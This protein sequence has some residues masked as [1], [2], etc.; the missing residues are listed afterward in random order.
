MLDQARQEPSVTIVTTRVPERAAKLG[1]R[2]TAQA[3]ADVM[4]LAGNKYSY[5]VQ[6]I[7]PGFRV[8]VF[9]EIIHVPR[10]SRAATCASSPHDY[11]GAIGV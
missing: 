3:L 6:D 5:R 10:Q 9:R 11:S 1:V 2:S 7:D 4:S 8:A